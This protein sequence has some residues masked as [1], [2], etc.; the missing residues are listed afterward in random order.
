L[1]QSLQ[2]GLGMMTALMVVPTFERSLPILETPQEVDPTKA[3]PGDLNGEIEV[4]HVSFRYSSDGPAILNDVPIDIPAGK[5]V[6]IVGPSGSGKST[7]LR[8]MLG[9]EQPESGAIYYDGRD[10][11]Q[12][13][14]QKLRRRIGVV[15]QN[16]KI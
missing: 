12:L 15:I 1:N 3:D 8:L 10:L 13:D 9:L 6:A 4:S 14:V 11:S 5:F 7:L 16:A 2:M